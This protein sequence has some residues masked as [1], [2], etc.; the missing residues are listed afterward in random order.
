MPRRAVLL[1]AMLATA[2]SHS[3]AQAPPPA[4]GAVAKS[5]QDSWNSAKR[6]I[7]ESAKLMP[8][9]HYA[10]K[11]ADSVRTF[12]Q[13]L[14]HIAGAN[15][16][17]CASAKGTTTNIAEDQFEKGPITKGVVKPLADSMAYCDSVFA[18]LTDAQ[19]AQPIDLPFGMG[20]GPR[21][22]AIVGNISHLN[23]HYG[24]L[25]TYMRIKGI[26]PPSSRR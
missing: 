15:H 23:E 9:E 13:I 10:F 5:L 22:A 4:A 3:A 20:K 26:V 6:N 1:L 24:N 7:T 16:I 25:V 19:L 2:G 17:F 11:P 8:E 21:S 18:G 14:G 12:G